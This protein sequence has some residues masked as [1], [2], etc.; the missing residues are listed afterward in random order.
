MKPKR[1]SNEQ[2]Q[3]IANSTSLRKLY[4]KR[5]S[6][7]QDFQEICDSIKYIKD[8]DKANLKIDESIKLRNEINDIDIKIESHERLT[9]GEWRHVR[10]TK[11]KTTTR[12]LGNKHSLNR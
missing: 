7:E 8:R 2:Q 3:R 6:L 1:R 4:S 10:E 5:K 12:N 11:T 9:A